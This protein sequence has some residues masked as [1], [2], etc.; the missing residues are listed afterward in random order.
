MTLKL[1]HQDVTKL[2]NSVCQHWH[3]FSS[4][5]YHLIES[6][7][8]DKSVLFF[9]SVENT[10]F[11]TK[12]SRWDFCGVLFAGVLGFLG[13]FLVAWFLGWFGFLWQVGKEGVKVRLPRF[14]RTSISQ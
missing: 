4:D 8:C 7:G 9:M 10:N 13:F 14:E 1:L 3:I 12:T 6:V 11:L 2:K 5:V